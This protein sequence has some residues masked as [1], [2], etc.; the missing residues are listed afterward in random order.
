MRSSDSSEIIVKVTPPKKRNKVGPKVETPTEE[1]VAKKLVYDT[2]DVSFAKVKA[3]HPERVHDM[4]RADEDTNSD[5]S[6]S[7]QHKAKER[8]KRS[9]P[10]VVELP[11]AGPREANQQVKK[12][13]GA[14]EGEQVK[15]KDKIEAPVEDKGENRKSTY[16]SKPRRYAF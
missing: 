6:A 15:D 13:Q 16:V 3:S 9:T 14:E 12:T 11:V 8:A 7:V 5:S 10:T 2:F 4:L 1:D